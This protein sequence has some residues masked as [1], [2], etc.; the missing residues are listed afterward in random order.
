MS[1]QWYKSVFISDT[2]LGTRGSNAELLDDFL[3]NI[4][5]DQLFLI[6]DI[7]DGW[8]IKSSFYWPQSHNNVIRKILGKA[9]KGTNVYYITGN[10]DEFLRDF[11]NYGLTVGNIQIVDETEFITQDSRHFLVTHG[12]AFDGIIRYHRW[13]AFLGDW[14]YNLA[15]WLNR[16]VNQFRQTFGYG[17]WSLSK[18]LKD[19]VKSAANFINQFETAVSNE[20]KNRNFDGIF[21]GHI[22]Y[23]EIRE[24]NGILYCNT[25][26]WVENCTAIVEHGDGTLELIHWK[27]KG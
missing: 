10:H 24:I 1:K 3:K 12:D 26:D 23:P 20:C 25:G 27:Q 6:G 22:H 17:H 8:R 7:V 14:A 2:H 21:C 18:F 11:T 4:E 16:V 13:V 9:K 5:T 19:K 15:I